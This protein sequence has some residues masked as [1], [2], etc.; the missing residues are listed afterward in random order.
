M[1]KID[2]LG[3]SGYKGGHM[4]KLLSLLILVFCLGIFTAQAESHVL[5]APATKKL[6]QSAGTGHKAKKHRKKHHRKSHKRH[7][8][9]HHV[10]FASS[11]GEHWQK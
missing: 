11:T 3:I 5:A 7:Q 6:E 1:L 4:K 2:R 8:S 10:S 9:R